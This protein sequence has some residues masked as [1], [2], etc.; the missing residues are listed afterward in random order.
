VLDLPL[1]DEVPH[2]PRHVLDRHLRIDAVLVEEIDLIDMKPSQGGLGD[3]PDVL[4]PAVET[5]PRLASRVDLEAELAGDHHL[6]TNGGEGLTHELLV[7]EWAVGLRRVE[8]RHAPVHRRPDQRDR[9][10]LIPG[11]AIGRGHAHA[12]ETKRRYFESLSQPAPRQHARPQVDDPCA[13][14][15]LE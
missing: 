7:R 6:P 13:G 9:C 3:L 14:Y 4:G 10:L 8:E 1:S 11:W 2:R 15:R 5:S 12:P